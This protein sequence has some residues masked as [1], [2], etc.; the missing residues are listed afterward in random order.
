[1][2]VLNALFAL[3][4]VRNDSLV[5]IDEIELALHPRVQ[6]NFLNFLKNLAQAK[7]LTVI[8]STHS[9]SLIKAAPNLIYIERQ[10]NGDIAIEYDCYPAIALQNIAIQEEILPDFA[11]FVEDEFAKYLLE[12]MLDFYFRN[13]N[14]SR[15]PIIK[16]L[17][18]GGY[19][20]TIKLT[21][22]SQGYLMPFNTTALCFLDL[23]VQVSIQQ[24][25]IKA[26]LSPPEI[27]ELQ[28]FQ[29]NN[30]LIRYLPIT[31]ELG[32]VNMLFAN[33]VQHRM[34]MQ[35]FSNQVFDIEQIVNA[36]NNRGIAYSPNPRVA[37]KA[38]IT[39]YIQQINQATNIDVTRIKVMLCQYFVEQTY[40]N[41]FGPLQA[42]FN[43]IFI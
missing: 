34:P 11:F 1:M 17:P 9:S 10:A 19:K 37:A 25:V 21:R 15:R 16:T 39:Y 31:P 40:T 3:N 14:V 12:A 28:L 36:E 23:D 13:V 22:N 7:N 4:T 2:L 18:V 20:E 5:L 30:T 24:L 43:P 6:Y 32:I 27:E 42:L 35:N 8:I 26:N 41:Q 38:R 29:A 33:P